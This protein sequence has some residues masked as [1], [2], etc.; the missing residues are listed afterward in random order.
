MANSMPKTYHHQPSRYATLRRK[1]YICPDCLIWIVR[2]RRKDLFLCLQCGRKETR[3]EFTQTLKRNQEEYERNNTAQKLLRK[4]TTSI[5]TGVV[6]YIKFGDRIKIGTTYDLHKRLISIPWDEVLLTEPGG[7]KLESDRHKQFKSSNYRNEW[8]NATDELMDFIVKRRE[9]LRE[10]NQDYWIC[11][12][13]FPWPYG[14]GIP[15]RQGMNRQTQDNLK[16]LA[17]Q[18]GYSMG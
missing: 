3:E 15:K 12:G 1:Y 6:Y 16:F 9:E 10:Y 7:Y 8:F 17:D 4:A 13:E 18:Y 14:T 2:D 5:S 11:M